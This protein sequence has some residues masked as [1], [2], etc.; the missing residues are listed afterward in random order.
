MK[1][2]PTTTRDTRIELIRLGAL[3]RQRLGQ[4]AGYQRLPDG[5]HIV[6]F[7]GQRFVGATVEE[8]ITATKAWRAKG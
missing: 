3:V 7:R 4:S 6:T 8:A 2:S 5:R 1:K